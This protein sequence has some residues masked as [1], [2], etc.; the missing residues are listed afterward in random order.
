MSAEYKKLDAKVKATWEEQAKEDKLRYNK[1]MSTYK[2][3][4]QLCSTEN[5]DDTTAAN[6]LAS[7]KE[8]PSILQALAACPPSKSKGDKS[9]KQTIV[10]ANTATS[11]PTTKAKPVLT[12]EEIFR[13]T[14]FT[15]LR[16]K[17]YLRAVQLT[18]RPVSDDFIE[19][20]LSV[21]TADLSS[22]E[23]GSVEVD[24]IFPDQ[25]LPY[26]MV[27]VQGSP[28]P[29]ST[30]AG[31]AHQE[32]SAFVNE[33]QHLTLDLVASK[34]KLVAQRKS[35]LNAPSQLDCFENNE[36]SYM[37]RW[38][39]SSTDLLPP[40]DAAKVKKARAAR[41]KLQNHHKAII[42]L[43]SAIDKA[44]SSIEANSSSSEKVVAKVSDMEEKVLKF[45]REEETAR[46]LNKAK[47]KKQA[48]DSSKKEEEKANKEA[49]KERKKIE[50]AKE[51][52]AE[53]QRKA[54]E[55]EKEKIAK[56]QDLEAKE[57]KRKARMMSFFSLGSAKKKQ[58]LLST[59]PKETS[60]VRKGNNASF[61]SD[62]FRRSINSGTKH[63]F[64]AFTKA[65]RKRKTR[66][67]FTLFHDTCLYAN[68]STICFILSH[69]RCE[70][71]SFCDSHL[72]QPVL[73][74]TL[75]RRKNYYRP[76]RV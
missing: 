61:D 41:K 76:Q 3:P 28:L 72:R 33:S 10:S 54:D 62:S 15:T 17:Y 64:T 6:K 34:I 2:P 14:N 25:L 51:R 69:I 39:L 63:T 7:N 20:R 30:L 9:T 48:E 75:R 22:I 70:S 12:E 57:N 71:L 13:L 68:V 44:I 16:E 18:S 27:I 5:I 46:L 59:P 55:K 1:E 8:K 45:E 11:N 19:E 21:E 29:L 58:K 36:E 38:E 23:K 35:F 73:P 56:Q 26:L 53:K 42:N 60:I 32:L 74:T 47:A 52:E 24:G 67:K 65:S 4:E 31:E 50:A 40:K 37:W 43:I 66:S 49:E